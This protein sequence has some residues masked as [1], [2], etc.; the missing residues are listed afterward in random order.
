MSPVTE[1]E[2]PLPA[3]PQLAVK[4]THRGPTVSILTRFG[5]AIGLA[6]I[7]WLLVV[8]ESGGWPRASR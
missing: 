8:V 6:L 5:L 3:Q 1:S 2:G 4:A 7:N